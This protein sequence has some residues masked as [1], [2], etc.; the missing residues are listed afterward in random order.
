VEETTAQGGLKVTDQEG[1]EHL[2]K[3]CVIGPSWGL[4]A[5]QEVELGRISV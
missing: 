2:I 4:P 5:T 1:L 3:K